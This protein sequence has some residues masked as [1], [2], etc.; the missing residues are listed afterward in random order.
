MC[1]NA[2]IGR[3]GGGEEVELPNLSSIGEESLSIP[4]VDAIIGEIVNSKEVLELLSKSLIVGSFL[5]VQSAG[6]LEKV[7]KLGWVAVKELA[8]N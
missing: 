7:R 1:A 6:V 4:I 8:L 3:K 5:K 2:N